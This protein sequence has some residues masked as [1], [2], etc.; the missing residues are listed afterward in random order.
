MAKE[1]F[2]LAHPPVM[3]V[4]W[5]I[6]PPP[7]TWASHDGNRFPPQPLASAALPDE[8]LRSALPVP[9]SPSQPGMGDG[10]PSA[11]QALFAHEGAQSLD[12]Q[13]GG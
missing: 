4:E 3:Q 9:P 12:Y 2:I 6:P 8:A 13:G 1:I 11:V 10:W 5:S 7:K